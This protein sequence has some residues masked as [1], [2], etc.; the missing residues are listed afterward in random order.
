MN[1]S[2]E[3]A[4]ARQH[5]AAYQILAYDDFFQRRIKWAN[6]ADTR[7][8]AIGRN[9]ESQLTQWLY[10]PC[11]LKVCRHHSGTWRKE[12]LDPRFGNETLLNRLLSQQTSCNQQLRVRGIGARRNRRNQDVTMT[13]FVGLSRARGTSWQ[14]MDG[15]VLLKLR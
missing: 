11:I 9:I 4:I 7:T 3:I 12:R 1:P 8:T 2:F 10:Q 5:S 13:H 6:V 15:V 14:R